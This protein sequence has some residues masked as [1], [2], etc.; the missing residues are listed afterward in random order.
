MFRIKIQIP[1]QEKGVVFKNNDLI[2]DAVTNALMKAGISYVDLYGSES[3]EW[4][5]GAV[6]SGFYRHEKELF[7]N[8]HEI[9]VSTT[10]DRISDALMRVKPSWFT[11]TQNSTSESIDM[12]G[13][14]I[15]EDLD[16]VMTPDMTEIPCRFLT[17]LV[18]AHTLERKTTEKRYVRDIRSINAS[19]NLSKRLSKISGRDINISIEPDSDY[20]AMTPNHSLRIDIKSGKHPVYA[21]GMMFPFM[22]KG[23]AEDLKFAWYAG[24]GIRNRMGM[25][26]IGLAN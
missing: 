5:A 14:I 17:P 21:F 4:S 23:K 13:A 20:L 16:P 12:S 22:L 8:S 2:K 25:G 3:P 18:V 26:I 15:G 6:T 7:R 11:K 1:Q 9:I 10:N 19:E 24:L